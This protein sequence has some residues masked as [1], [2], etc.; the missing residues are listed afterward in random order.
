MILQF[1]RFRQEIT[2]TLHLVFTDMSSLILQLE[3][4]TEIPLQAF[5]GGIALLSFVWLF[6]SLIPFLV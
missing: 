1:Y 2:E 6:L 3:A 4:M 5:F